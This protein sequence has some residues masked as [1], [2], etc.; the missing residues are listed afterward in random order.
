MDIILIYRSIVMFYCIYCILEPMVE[1]T[2]LQTPYITEYS[3]NIPTGLRLADG[4]LN[5][6]IKEATRNV[7]KYCLWFV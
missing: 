2:V 1:N 4:T 7:Y 6:A 3:D 5:F